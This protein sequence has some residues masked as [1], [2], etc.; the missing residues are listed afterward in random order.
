[1]PTIPP[2]QVSP[3]D[4]ADDGSP[5]VPTSIARPNIGPHR[6]Y[7]HR[8]D[9]DVD[10]VLRFRDLKARGIVRNWP[11]L[12]SWIGTENF[13]VGFQLG[14]NTRAW[15]ESDVVAWLR[16]RP[17]AGARARELIDS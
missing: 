12:L 17:V 10:I 4:G 11:T 8:G 15:F 16:S 3:Y 9:A 6:R 14:P 1:M 13:P 7:G 2:D 5:P